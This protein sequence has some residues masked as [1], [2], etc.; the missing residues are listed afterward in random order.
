MTAVRLEQQVARALTDLLRERRLR[1]H[2]LQRRLDL[3]PDAVDR[4]LSGQGGLEMDV[5][6]RVLTL[7]GVAPAPF[8][9]QLF[10][11]AGSP[12]TD[13]TSAG[14]GRQ[15]VAGLLEQVR[16]ALREIAPEEEPAG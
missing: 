13:G 6:R 16:R 1:P 4:L 12:A 11:D 3:S 10:Q 5:L 9:A 15:E 8:F 2:D 7:L 14:P